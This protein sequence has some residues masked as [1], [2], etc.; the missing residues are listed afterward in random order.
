MTRKNLHRAPLLIP[1]IA[2]ILSGCATVSPEAK[3]RAG[4]MDAG[5][6]ERMSACMAEKMVRRLSID[7]L[8]QLKSIVSVKDTDYHRLT[9]DR[10]LY[11]LRAVNDPEIFAVTSRAALSCAI[12]S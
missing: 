3:V 8:K 10:L 11:K 4:L 1:I 7:Q 9:V 12:S 2:L 5:L 6:S